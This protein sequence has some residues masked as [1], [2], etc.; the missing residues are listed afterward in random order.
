M[1]MRNE[2]KFAAA[3]LTLA[4]AIGCGAGTPGNT[5]TDAAPEASDDATT[6]D[7]ET[8]TD[9][10]TDRA[11]DRTDVA[12]D[13]A[14]AARTDA[15]SCPVSPT[16]TGTSLAGAMCA[17]DMACGS[18]LLSCDTD[19][20]GGYCSAECSNNAS[21]DCEMAQCGGRG[22]TCLALGDGAD[23]VTFCAPQCS[24]TARA[25]MPGTC[26]AG[27][28]CTGW[29]YTHNSGEPDRT[30]CEY[31][32]SSNDHCPAGMACN[33]RTGECGTA[34]STTLRA[35]GEPCDPTRDSGDGPS[36]QCRG[37][38]FAETDVERE[39]ICG[40]LLNIGATPNCPDNPTAVHP[41][42]PSDDNGRTDNL[43]L[44]IYHECTTDADCTLPLHCVDLMDG[45]PPV[46]TYGEGI[47][48]RDGGAPDATPADA[49]PVDAGAT[50]ASADRAGG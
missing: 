24:P 47:P 28:V 7:A 25:G 42:A 40:S 45:D 14:D 29:W 46:C 6:P 31:F 30:G 39:G 18:P 20:R 41:L 10:V 23:A 43:G 1:T 2:W 32:C 33:T 34:A 35:D 49:T 13:R 15:G 37:Y 9:T 50:D 17:N 19:F 26:R 5:P 8:P 36:T 27:T 22:S 48:A 16:P 21:Q 44:C 38:C 12:A 11:A 3:A 4:G